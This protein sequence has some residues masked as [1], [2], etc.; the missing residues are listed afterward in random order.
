MS[1]EIQDREIRGITAKVIFA[2]FF[3]CAGIVATVMGTYSRIISK[4]EVNKIIQDANNDRQSYEIQ[5]LR[6]EKDI[7][8]VRIREL[9]TFVN[10]NRSLIDNLSKRFKTK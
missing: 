7:M 5:G 3:S 9:E 2:V 10:E 6:E 1:T 4:M 8:K